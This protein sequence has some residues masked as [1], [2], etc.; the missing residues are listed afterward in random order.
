[1]RQFVIVL[2]LVI[3]I[4]CAVFDVRSHGLLQ[5]ENNLRHHTLKVNEA[6]DVR[7]V[8]DCFKC[9]IRFGWVGVVF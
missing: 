6:I 1:M 7:V 8:T 3:G 9:L 2:M 5:G 4:A